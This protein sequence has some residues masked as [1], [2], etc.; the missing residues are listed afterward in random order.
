MPPTPNEPQ[1]DHPHVVLVV[2]DNLDGLTSLV[3]LLELKGYEVIGASSG[4]EAI[5]LL[6]GGVRPC[7][8]VLDLIMPKV[9]GLTFRH[10]QTQSPELAAIPV[11]AL[12][13]HEGLRRQAQ[14]DG[15]AAALLK[16]VGIDDLCV[17]LG[18]HC[19]GRRDG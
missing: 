8:I 19:N 11:I 18:N 12:T 2:D 6:A 14:A 16:P 5:H 1:Q 10:W 13:G 4:E 7:A 9:D 3:L 15:F 17:L